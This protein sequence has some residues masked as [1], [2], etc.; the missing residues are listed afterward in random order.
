M[1]A[2]EEFKDAITSQ[3]KDY[4]PADFSN[5]TVSINSVLKNNS[6]KL[7]GLTIRREGESICPNIYLAQF[8]EDYIDWRALEDILSDIAKIRQKHSGPVDFDITAITDFDSVKS[9]TI[10]SMVFHTISPQT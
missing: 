10:K 2:Y 5:A 6:S 7:D 3:I 1:L 4:L 9:N 8:Y